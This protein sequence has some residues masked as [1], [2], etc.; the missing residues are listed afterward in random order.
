MV[1]FF[2]AFKAL[3]G[4][5]IS[6]ANTLSML[7]RRGFGV[8]VVCFLSLL[9]GCGASP[10]DFHLVA[11]GLGVD[12][13]ERDRNRDGTYIGS[14]VNDPG[15]KDQ[16]T[17]QHNGVSI[18][19]GGVAFVSIQSV[20]SCGA[21]RNP[22]IKETQFVIDQ[23]EMF[24]TLTF[25]QSTLKWSDFGSLQASFNLQCM[26]FVEVDGVGQWI[27]S[28]IVT[29][30]KSKSDGL[31]SADRPETLAPPSPLDLQ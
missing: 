23:G 13:P 4:G 29:I 18:A 1:G 11:P 31:M 2:K 10:E 20:L 27:T 26:V 17:V 7:V 3:C 24:E 28:D 14:P 25:T 21:D 30:S 19:P 15:S 8:L 6:I 16:I 12:D 22:E 5:G 9:T